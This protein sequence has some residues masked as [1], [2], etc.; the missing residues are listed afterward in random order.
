MGKIAFVFSGQGDQ[1]PGMGKELFESSAAAKEVFEL[2]E[3]I[4]NGTLKQ[5]FDGMEAE[6]K[7]TANTQPCLFAFELAAFAA[8]K[9]KGITPDMTAG[10]SLGEVSAATAA[11][12]FSVSEGFRLVC[13]R[14]RLMQKEAEKHDTFMAAVVKLSDSQ[15][16]KICEKY[17]DIFPVNYNCPGQITVSGAS[18]NS[19]E[20]FADVKAEGGRAIP[21][22]VNGAFHSPY[23]NEAASAFGEVL[24]RADIKAPVFPIYSNVT[25]DVYGENPK[26]LLSSQI[27]SPVRW[28]KII[29]NMIDCGADTFVEIGPGKTLTNMIKKTDGTVRAVTFTE[30]LEEADIC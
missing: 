3:S 26:E 19:S 22:K 29:R 7:E 28:E 5:C 13:E 25:A 15:V 20:F 6:L 16:E 17:S 30:Y 4:R 12:L 23:M 24:S 11:G 21:L 2:C 14:G 27:C 18:L 9:E 10:F 8:L 1:Y